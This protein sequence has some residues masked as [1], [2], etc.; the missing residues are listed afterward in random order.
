MELLFL[1]II[2]LL[3]G[4]G[5]GAVQDARTGMISDKINYAMIATGIIL[6]IIAFDWIGLLF[7]AVVFGIGFVVY[8]FGKIGGG[9]VKLFTGIAFLMPFYVGRIFVLSVLLVSAILAVIFY[10]V[11]YTLK[12]ARRGINWK[13]NTENL[14]KVFLFAIVFIAYFWFLAQ[15]KQVS[16]FALGFLGTGFAFGLLFLAFEKG[17]RKNFFLKKISLSKLE[18]DEVIASEFIDEK[19]KKVLG[20]GMKGILGEKEKQKLE[21]AG[22]KEIPVYRNMPPF[23]PFIFLAI[24]VVL[25][26]PDF[27]GFLF[28]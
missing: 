21:K 17:I 10:S 18:E 28:I 13:E 7:V 20:A 2:A 14:K 27:L 8:Y 3:A 1:R 25:L 12:Y 22:I 19:I 4:S 23:A 6:N 9:D 15:T 11:F 26:K 24:I 5:L 16:V